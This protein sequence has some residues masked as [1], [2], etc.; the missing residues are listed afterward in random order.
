MISFE[1]GH[2]AKAPEIDYTH[3]HSE[4]WF[5]KV[6]ANDTAENSP[7]LYVHLCPHSHDDVGWLKTVDE[8]FT[9]SAQNIQH[10]E[11]Q[12]IIDN[13]MNELIKDPNK[14][15]TQVEMKFFT[16]WWDRQTDDMKDTVRNLVKEGRLD[17]V[18]AGW[19]MH[20]EACTHHDDMMNNMMIGHEFLEKEFNF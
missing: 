3:G 19:S 20:D 5:E 9:G 2:A 11:V 17:F 8:Y 6:Y 10:A 18:N 14:R 15:F 13:Y 16:M 12:M 7:H 1:L 4:E